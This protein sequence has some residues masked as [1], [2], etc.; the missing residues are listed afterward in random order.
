M[1]VQSFI[2]SDTLQL[3]L[4]L[5][6]YE[7]IPE[8]IKNTLEEVS[9]FLSS[10]FQEYFILFDVAFFTYKLLEAQLKQIKL[11]QQKKNPLLIPLYQVDMYEF[12]SYI[13]IASTELIK[14]SLYILSLIHYKEFY[15]QSTFQ[16][17]LNPV[18]TTQ[19]V[20][21]E[22]SSFALS[23]FKQAFS[24]FYISFLQLPLNQVCTAFLF[25]LLDLISIYT[26]VLT[27]KY[28]PLYE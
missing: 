24:S 19:E 20:F 14:R 25:L 23:H 27:R 6:S 11:Q 22:Q 8:Q 12:Y 4:I 1:Y 15:Q 10:Y 18:Q 26:L 21:I 28:L 17:L 7:T 13:F 5:L 2:S 16:T 9:S 3:L